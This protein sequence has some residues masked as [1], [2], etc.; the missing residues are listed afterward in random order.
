MLLIVLVDRRVQSRDDKPADRVALALRRQ[1]WQSLLNWLREPIPFPGMTFDFEP[2]QT[3][4][5]QDRSTASKS[6][7][8]R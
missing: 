1:T 4:Y 6:A 7:Q 2:R 3:S 5:N 8:T